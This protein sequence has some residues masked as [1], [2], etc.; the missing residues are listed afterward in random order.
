MLNKNEPG[1]V[2]NTLP[3]SFTESFI[4]VNSP[5]FGELF[6]DFLELFWRQFELFAV[7]IDIIFALHGDQMDVR[8]GNFEAQDDYSDLF[9]GEF[10]TDFGGHLLGEHHHAAERL[11]VEI[12]QIV[13][14]LLRNDERMSFSQRINVQKGVIAVIFGHFVR[15]DLPSDDA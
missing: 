3:D 4:F 11:I 14:L 13:Y 12:E 9:A 8:M 6:G 10:A 15:G 2:Y 5:L 1:C 7:E